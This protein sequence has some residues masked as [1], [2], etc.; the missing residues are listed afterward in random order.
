MKKKLLFY[1]ITAAVFICFMSC[2]YPAIKNWWE[3]QGTA[4]NGGSGSTNGKVDPVVRWPKD[5]KAIFG[6]KLYDI[7]LPCNC[8]TT[9]THGT[10]TWTKP[11]ISLGK[12]RKQIY[13]MTFTPD[14]TSH[15]NTVTK[16]VEVTI[17]VINMVKIP[18]G[19]FMMGSPDTEPERGSNEFLHQ[20]TLSGFSMSEYT[21]TQEL[22]ELVMKDNPDPFTEAVEGENETP[23]QLPIT[24]VRWYGALVF[25]NKLS[26]MMGLT[27]AYRIPA[28]NNSTDPEDWGKV[29]SA[30][31]DPNS[32]LWDTVEIVPDSNGYR[33]PT[34]AQWEY[35][36]RA[37]TTTAFNTGDTADC[38]TGWYNDGR[39]P[40]EDLTPHKVG[41]LPSNAW[42][43]YD[44]HGNV[45]EWC[46][47]W[48]D[49]SYYLN[50]PTNDPMGPSG[51]F[52]W[53]KRVF[54]GG[55][56]FSL[57]SKLRSAARPHDIVYS[58]V[59]RCGIRLVRPFR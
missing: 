30:L 49:Y 5:L 2:E 52:I 47:D 40:T 39:L 38:D 36:C 41:M 26:M 51:Q 21:V 11:N 58:R 55:E 37:G 59:Q 3:E 23:E 54:R 20:V 19:T 48:Y 17:I 14:D 6:Q 42:G 35:A 33:L 28:F 31:E 56:Y 4:G 7:A 24:V 16:D 13:N 18:A 57:P 44:M 27:P 25:C 46:W 12:K 9:E 15:Y 32:T 50:S 8:T 53:C 1:L 29:P 34:E 43:L 22:Y 45:S 10:F